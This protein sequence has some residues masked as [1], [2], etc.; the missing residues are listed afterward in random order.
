M[1]SGGYSLCLW[2]RIPFQ[3][4]R[5]SLCSLWLWYLGG[6]GHWTCHGQETPPGSLS[7]GVPRHWKVFSL[8]NNW[9]TAREWWGSQ[10]LLHAEFGSCCKKWT[11]PFHKSQ[12]FTSVNR[13]VSPLPAYHETL[14][15]WLRRSPTGNVR[16]SSFQLPWL[17]GR[18]S[19]SL[20]R[21]PPKVQVL[22]LLP[23]L[24]SSEMHPCLSPALQ[25]DLKCSLLTTAKY[26]QHS[27]WRLK[28]VGWDFSLMQD[29]VKPYN[30]NTMKAKQ[31][32]LE[33][34][35]NYSGLD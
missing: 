18:R 10:L 19:W 1:A 7:M 27:P 32:S 20:F 13:E 16:G 29:Q 8:I 5:V 17:E 28:S 34:P 26:Q 23:L 31:R 35:G 15:C 25:A 2:V 9:G 30:K 6:F 21:I 22:E 33:N 12:N 24:K 11:A 4:A 3:Q 14:M